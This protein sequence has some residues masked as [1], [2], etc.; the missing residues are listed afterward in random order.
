MKQGPNV[1]EA[2]LLTLQLGRIQVNRVAVSAQVGCCILQK[3]GGLRNRPRNRRERSVHPNDRLKLG[4]AGVDAVESPLLIAQGGLS[5]MSGGCEELGM[6][7]P[8]E[9]YLKILELG[10]PGIDLI[11]GCNKITRVL[12]LAILRPRKL[13]DFVELIFCQGT[14]SKSLLIREAKIGQFV[15]GPRI[16]H[17]KMLG[18]IE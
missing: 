16:E 13:N 2:A 4:Q 12:Q 14:S 3:N 8:R 6:L 7:D 10:I 15:A 1:G 18:G 9:C 11:Y 5:R 17:L